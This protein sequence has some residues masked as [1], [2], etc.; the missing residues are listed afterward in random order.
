MVVEDTGTSSFNDILIENN[1]IRAVRNI[2]LVACLN[3]TSAR[4]VIIRGNT[5][6]DV[7][8]NAIIVRICD[9]TCLIEHNLCYDTAT[10]TT[11]NTM[12][13][14][15]VNG[16]VFQYNEG[17]NNMAGDHDGSLYDADLNS[18]NVV[19]QYSYSHDNSHG[20]YWQYGSS[21]ADTGNV[22]RYN[23]SQNDHGNIFS[24][25]GS[26]GSDYVYNNT[27][28]I[29][30]TNVPPTNLPRNIIDDRSSSHKEYFYNNI[31]YNL[32]PSAQYH[33]TSGNTHTFDHNVFFGEHPTSEPADTNK[34]TSDPML[35]SPGTGRTNDFGSLAGY[36]LQAG[37][38][39]IDSGLLITTN[40]AGNAN[41]AALDFFNNAV[42][43]N[44]A[45]D[46]GAHEWTPPLAA[47]L[48]FGTVFSSNGVFSF[49]FTNIPSMNFAVFRCTNVSLAA[50]NWSVAGT[51]VEVATG[52]YQFRE[53]NP[54]TAQQ[55]YRV[56]SP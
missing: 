27:I 26:G 31:F 7:A 6:H 13:T 52:Q 38:P 14:A 15:A 24:F 22:C 44:T 40:L 33:L 54:A 23:I 19:F 50:S 39:C 37:S 17:Y 43:F 30:Q 48:L 4:N 29:P 2:G 56:R 34:L 36:K 21:T 11:G 12:F 32:S 53:T 47:P 25:S 9:N 20:L 8:K 49:L 45:T 3:A 1:E 5:I 41:T 18:K 51:A 28:F 35:V 55:F 46:R 42:P 16:P 10:M